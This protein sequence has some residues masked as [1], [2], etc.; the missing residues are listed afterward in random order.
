MKARNVGIIM[1]IPALAIMLLFIVYPTALAIYY[2]FTDYNVVKGSI[3]FIGASNFV[4]LLS[5]YKLINSITRTLMFMALAVSLSMVTG[6]VMAVL[7]YE[8]M[9]GRKIFATLFILPLAIPYVIIGLAFKFML[10]YDIGV[11]NYFLEV[12][13]IGRV[14]FF[15]KPD[16]ALLATALVDSWPGSAF[17]FL[18]TLAG[19]E[20][21]PR[22]IV[23]AALIDGASSFRLYMH[24]LFP[25]IKRFLV[26]ALL[27]R[28][29]DSFKAFDHIYMMTAGGPGEATQY[30]SI[31]ITKTSFD[32]F[33]LGYACA[34]AIVI[35]LALS[36]LAQALIKML[37][38]QKLRTTG[39][40]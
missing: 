17:V 14:P 6:I 5:D 19:F 33:N 32:Y 20:S 37:G 23:E 9:L 16:L 39:W 27:F 1:L 11:I 8:C 13:G 28:L 25:M 7:I 10:S 36:L 26:I 40:R 15:G 4:K 34:L 31:Y 38:L 35:L 22:R 30:I 12:I 2:S 24:V 18:V 21:I 29:L 3:N